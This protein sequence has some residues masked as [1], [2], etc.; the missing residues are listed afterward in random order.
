MPRR[1][2]LSVTLTPPR[3]KNLLGLPAPQARGLSYPPKGTAKGTATGAA[4]GTTG[5]LNRQVRRLVRRRCKLEIVPGATDPFRKA[6]MLG[7]CVGRACAW[8]QKDPAT[9]GAV[10]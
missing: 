9:G 7:A 3:G 1:P 8:F 10:P 4:T 5:A 6:G 2:T